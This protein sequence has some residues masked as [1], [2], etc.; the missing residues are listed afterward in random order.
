MKSDI[1]QLERD[2]S[3]GVLISRYRIDEVIAAL[4]AAANWEQAAIAQDAKLR[5][6]C[7]E[8]GAMEKLSAVLAQAV[9]HIDCEEVKKLRGL[10]LKA[11]ELWWP[12]VPNIASSAAT[13]LYKQLSDGIQ[14]AKALPPVD[15]KRRWK[16]VANKCNTSIEPG[17][18]G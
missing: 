15:D 16:Y 5:A 4:R 10:I 18:R 11:L 12:F 6:M 9:D 17:E 13:G 8:P 1:D 14:P 7:D 2:L 3:N